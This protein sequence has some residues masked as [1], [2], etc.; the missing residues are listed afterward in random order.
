MSKMEKI[1]VDARTM[2]VA[3]LGRPFKLGMLY[4][5]DTDELIQNSFLWDRSRLL[6]YTRTVSDETEETKVI[7]TD[8]FNSKA[9]ALEMCER[10]KLSV[11]SGLTKTLGAANYFN[12]TQNSSNQERMVLKF[13]C[14]TK[15]EYFEEDILENILK[16]QQ[17]GCTS[18]VGTHVVSA[19]SYGAQVFFV[20]DKYRSSQSRNADTVGAFTELIRA[21]PKLHSFKNPIDK[22]TN[23]QKTLAE[24]L[25]IQTYGDILPTKSPSTYEDAVIV[26][27]GLS[28]LLGKNGQKAVPITAWLHPVGNKQFVV[29]EI[30]S[31]QA[32][33]FQQVIVE[34]E[35]AMINVSDLKE[36]RVCQNIPGLLSEVECFK[37][38]IGV[39]RDEWK[40]EFSRMLPRVRAGECEESMLVS[41]LERHNCS[42]FCGREIFLWL[43]EKQSEITILQRFVQTVNRIE[44]A[45][46]PGRLEATY[47]DPANKKVF[48]FVIHR[49][50]NDP[51]LQKM[52]TYLIN[53]EYAS[54][55]LAASDIH[56]QEQGEPRKQNI[57]KAARNFI[58]LYQDLGHVL[59]TKFLLVEEQSES[60][61]LTATVTLYEDGTLDE[62]FCS[63]TA[64]NTGHEMKSGSGYEYE[65]KVTSC[66]S[67]HQG[68]PSLLE[69]SSSQ[70]GA[71]S[72]IQERAGN[73]YPKNSIPQKQTNML[74][75][76]AD[77]KWIKKP[78]KDDQFEL[79]QDQ[80]ETMDYKNC[81]N[82]LSMTQVHFGDLQKE[83]T[84]E[85]TA[86]LHVRKSFQ[87]VPISFSEDLSLILKPESPVVTEISHNSVTLRWEEPKNHKSTITEYDVS[88]KEINGWEQIVK[89][90]SKVNT[91]TAT[92]LEPGQFYQFKVRTY[93]G[94]KMSEYSNATKPTQ[95]LPSSPPGKPKICQ[96]SSSTAEIKWTRPAVIGSEITIESY[97]LKAS[98]SDLNH[99]KDWF[100]LQ[101]IPGDKTETEVGLNPGVTYN[102]KVI[103]DCGNSG[104]SMESLEC[105]NFCGAKLDVSAKNSDQ[106]SQNFNGEE[107]CLTL[108]PTS[109]I[110]S[111]ISHDCVTLTWKEPVNLNIPITEYEVSRKEIDGYEQIIKTGSTLNTYTFPCLEPGR[112][113]QFRIRMSTG[114]SMSMY[115]DVTE[116]VKTLPSSPPGKP[117][118]RQISATTARLKWTRPEEVG[119]QVTINS[120]VIMAY[121]S[122]P[123][124]GNVWFELDRTPAD[125]TMTE[126]S[127]SPLFKYNFKIFADC[128]KDGNSRES[129]E[130]S[131][132]CGEKFEADAKAVKHSIEAAMKLDLRHV[133]G[134]SPEVHQIMLGRPKYTN[135]QLK[136]RKYDLGQELTGSVKNEKVVLLLGATGSGKS[137][138][139]NGI[140]NYILGVTWKDSS[141]FKLVDESTSGKKSASQAKSQTI[142]I[143]SYTIHHQSEYRVPY[144]LT[145]VDTPGFG[146]TSGIQRDKEIMQQIKQ[147]FNSGG[148]MGIDQ[149]DAVGFV[150][151]SSLPRLT[152]TQKFIYDSI[153]SLFGKDI[154]G[155]IFMLLTFSDGQRPPVLGGLKEAGLP[156]EEKFFKFNN[157]ALFARNVCDESKDEDVQAM[158]FDRKFW[159][160][161]T[162]SYKQFL[163]HL[164]K[165]EAKSLSLSKEVLDERQRLEVYI[166]GLQIDVQY[167]LN[168]LEQL[169]VE[170]RILK[171]HEADI[172][173]NADFE[174][175]VMEEIAVLTPTEP[176]TYTTNCIR[177]KK[178]C[179]YPCYLGDDASK[180]SCLVMENGTCKLCCCYWKMHRNL[181][182]Y[183]TIKREEKKKNVT[184]LQSRYQNAMGKQYSTQKLI[185]TIKDDV[186]KHHQI[187]FDTI[188]KIT[189]SLKRL[190]E[191]ALKRS[192]LSAVQYIETLIQSE[193]HE[194]KP[195]YEMRVQQ[196]SKVRDYAFSQRKGGRW[197]NWYSK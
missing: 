141:R 126:V 3:A 89:T 109:P 29:K 52:N 91:F 188:S 11:L 16:I 173:K 139:I 37:R 113:Y 59:S 174:Y 50:V 131:E 99:G 108:K 33:A 30:G 8:S 176:G 122:D 19:I 192:N 151:Q 39:Y 186:K 196:L 161:G 47:M 58:K 130:S 42:P 73:Q 190:D 155:N 197:Y 97:I 7:S 164:K 178:T 84:E 177:C 118:L 45:T 105:G 62:K 129:E 158:K 82:G 85:N 124:D 70:E 154:L 79:S 12:D 72:H 166:E 157:S 120:F 147:L 101:Y 26:Y 78:L 69:V 182:H 112:V 18:L 160:M 17:S 13:R 145:V 15:K 25:C 81:R 34:L 189:S 90:G 149:I 28:G 31:I 35:R 36:T 22:L 179:H 106:N 142:W 115:S 181:P 56:L 138:L 80:G 2:E 75:T 110:V 63:E 92:D 49:P 74:H 195:G 169:E 43:A 175:T 88:C 21:I 153:L 54:N 1:T 60:A 144:T 71:F 168:K 24:S 103:A 165:V 9:N 98:A 180:E 48:C 77:S 123:K 41:C 167:T 163:N 46:K 100:I 116:P 172:K 121:S 104:Q 156:L 66:P 159:K 96:I 20:F 94:S 64:G 55:I 114:R 143:T 148:Q 40:K 57:T 65:P 191:I 4:N 127:L 86:K 27:R 107:D 83:S 67:E 5:C 137:T 76:E 95:T 44:F 32:D 10:L 171:N 150:V 23:E 193:R 53:R 140:V 194:A 184:A 128:G 6:Q 187:A 170:Q 117:S 125:K 111:E 136:L 61:D 183:Y 133:S 162:T 152:P 68:Q 102:Y 51:I 14:T 93:A 135:N 146:D 132:F 134:K 119:S 38:L 185:E 87:N